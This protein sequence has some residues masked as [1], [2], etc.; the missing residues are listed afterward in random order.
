MELERKEL[1]IVMIYW[2]IIIICDFSLSLKS[3]QSQ[4]RCMSHK[5]S[6]EMS[7]SSVHEHVCVATVL[8]ILAEIECKFRELSQRQLTSGAQVYMNRL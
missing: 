2:S 6:M 5:Q 8:Q 4:V 7:K 1:V 3:Y